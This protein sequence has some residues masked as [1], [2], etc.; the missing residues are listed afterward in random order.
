MYCREG[1]FFITKRMNDIAVSSCI[2]LV[3]RANLKLHKSPTLKIGLK[4]S[5]VCGFV[6]VILR[7]DI[8]L[9]FLKTI[10][11]YFDDIRFSQYDL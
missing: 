10:Q 1:R 9:M 3:R 7:L 6:S 2:P 4:G 11:L 8:L 5:K